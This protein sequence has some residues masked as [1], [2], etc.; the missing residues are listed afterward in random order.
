MLCDVYGHLLS[1]DGHDFFGSYKLN[2]DE[3]CCD[4]ELFIPVASLSPNF[5]TW[6]GQIALFAYK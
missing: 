5:E 2:Y 1:F 3:M 4:N 6:A